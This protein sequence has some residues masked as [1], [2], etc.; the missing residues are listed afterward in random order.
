MAMN[1]EV[2]LLLYLQPACIA[3]TEKKQMWRESPD[4]DSGF[5]V[6]CSHFSALVLAYCLSVSQV[7][8]NIDIPVENVMQLSDIHY[9][10]D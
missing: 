3:K 10:D 4:A 9:L 6:R 2:Q 8:T 5:T 7:V 1:L